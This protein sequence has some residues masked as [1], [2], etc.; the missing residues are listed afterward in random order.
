MSRNHHD[1]GPTRA[2]VLATLQGADRALA[3]AEVADELKLHRNS[4]RF[5]L[6]A[7]VDRGFAVREAVRSEGAGRPPLRYRA[8]NKS[9]TVGNRHLTELL[10]VLLDIM[11]TANQEQLSLAQHAG[12][13]WGSSAAAQAQPG[14]AAE[15]LV[16]ELGERGFATAREPKSIRF[17]RCPFRDALSPD[18]LKLVCSIHQGFIDGF[19]AHNMDGTRAG[20][21]K[22]GR[23]TCRI[24]LT[25]GPP[26][27]SR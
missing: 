16:T 19:L 3:V 13:A 18:Q 22:V 24:E 17:T 2:K 7:L 14:P 20:S 25:D 6:D 1:L 23:T 12:A 11:P 5:H 26:D 4:A 27:P 10:G 8:T 15:Q 9:P 21:L